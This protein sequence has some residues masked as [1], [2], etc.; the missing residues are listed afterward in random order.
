MDAPTAFLFLPTQTK[1]S[2]GNAIQ[3]YRVVQNKDKDIHDKQNILRIVACPIYNSPAALVGTV[4][5][6]L[7]Y[8]IYYVK[9]RGN[10]DSGKLFAVEFSV[11]QT[12]A[13][14]FDVRYIKYN[15]GT[16]S[17]V[18]PNVTPVTL[19]QLNNYIQYGAN[20]N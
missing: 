1:V 17:E 8:S 13:V 10:E 19:D 14:P 18:N 15:A 5:D 9:F 20:Y 2:P 16:P 3:T 4:V 7:C 11:S 6:K 12:S